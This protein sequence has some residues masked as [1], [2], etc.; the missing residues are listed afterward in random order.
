MNDTNKIMKCFLNVMSPEFIGLIH[1]ALL[2][3]SSKSTKPDI[4][5]M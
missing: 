1:D 4:H 5:D 3:D 2:L